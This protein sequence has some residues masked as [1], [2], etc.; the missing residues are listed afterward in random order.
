MGNELKH[1]W[2][3]G[4][5]S[6]HERGYGNAWER[7]R[8]QALERDRYLCQPCLK[9][10]KPVVAKIVDH[11]KPKAQ[12]GTDDLDNLQTICAPCHLDKT[13]RE[14]GKRR[15]PQFGDDGWPI[16]PEDEA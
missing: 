13:L 3:H 8:K 4:G 9:G 10:G 15:R 7:V 5:R 1:N 2:D 11:I 16:W 14:N 12:G 6:R